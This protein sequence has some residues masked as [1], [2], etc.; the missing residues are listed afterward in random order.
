MKDGILES[1]SSKRLIFA[2]AVALTDLQRT[3]AEIACRQC[4]TDDSFG[5]SPQ[6]SRD[7]N[8]DGACEWL[9]SSSRIMTYVYD[10]LATQDIVRTDAANVRA[11][12]ERLLAGAPGRFPGY[13]EAVEREP[14]VAAGY[15]RLLD[16][17]EAMAI[18]ASR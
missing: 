14:A 18:S 9:R 7:L 13:F 16:V 1:S 5:V 3:L 11:A 17:L 10:L 6:V 2:L 12:V 15:A 4:E 8:T